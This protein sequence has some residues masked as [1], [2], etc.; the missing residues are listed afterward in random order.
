MKITIEIL[1]DIEA[2]K[3]DDLDLLMV[4]VKSENITHYEYGF[5]DELEALSWIRH[6]DLIEYI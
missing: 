1:E 3:H 2:K 5:V 6:T 4:K